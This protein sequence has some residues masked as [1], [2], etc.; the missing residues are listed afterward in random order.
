MRGSCSRDELL[1][2]RDHAMTTDARAVR[3]APR[4]CVQMLLIVSHDRPTSGSQRVP[5]VRPSRLRNAASAARVSPP[6]RSH[7]ACRVADANESCSTDRLRSRD[8]RTPRQEHIRE[9]APPLRLPPSPE[10][11]PPGDSGQ[12]SNACMPQCLI[13]GLSAAGGWN[14]SALVDDQGFPLLTKCEM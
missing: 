10:S 14:D 4:G 7:Q 6:W 12:A 3:P 11:A 9:R 1:G 2:Y 5:N 13:V 8:K